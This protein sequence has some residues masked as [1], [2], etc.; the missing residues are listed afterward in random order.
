MFW[1]WIKITTM[2]MT[3]AMAMSEAHVRDEDKLETPFQELCCLDVFCY[4]EQSIIILMSKPIH[5]HFDPGRF[6]ALVNEVS[7]CIHGG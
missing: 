3:I 1:A 6:I 5:S 4:W 2:M 7:P